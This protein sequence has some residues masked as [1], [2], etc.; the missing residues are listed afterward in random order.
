MEKE[1]QITSMAMM[2]MTLL[3]E[4]II[5]ITYMVENGDDTLNGGND[6][7]TMEGGEW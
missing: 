5:M 4:V 2:E 3:M 1:G 7:D 6:L